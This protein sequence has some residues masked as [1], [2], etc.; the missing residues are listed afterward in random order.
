MEQFIDIVSQY[1]PMLDVL[2]N[3]E[4]PRRLATNGDMSPPRLSPVEHLLRVSRFHG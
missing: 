4:R 3:M 2:R 1:F